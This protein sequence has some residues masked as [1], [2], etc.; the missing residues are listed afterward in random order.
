M[1]LCLIVFIVS[2]TGFEIKAILV[3][4]MY[5]ATE[6]VTTIDIIAKPREAVFVATIAVRLATYKHFC[7]SKNICIAG[8]AKGVIDTSVT[9]I[10]KG[11]A[12]YD[13]FVTA[14]IEIFCFCQM[15]NGTFMRKY[16]WDTVEINGGTVFRVKFVNIVTI[17]IKDRCLI[18]VQLSLSYSTLL[19]TSEQLEGIAI[20]VVDGCTAPYLSVLTVS[21]TIYIEGRSHHV[22]TL[23]FK[24]YS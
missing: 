8:T 6:V 1:Y 19:T 11:V 3:S 16:S 17:L 7:M 23:T 15:L 10:Y 20:I 21:G 4:T 24:I 22:V 5:G 12:C 2:Y 13:T 18:S 9:E 14:T